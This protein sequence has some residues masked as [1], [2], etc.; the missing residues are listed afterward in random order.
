MVRKLLKNLY[1][2]KDAGR[3]WFEHLSDGL[4]CMGFIPTNSD[5]CIFTKGST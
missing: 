1:G 3:T 4:L 5:P 2:L